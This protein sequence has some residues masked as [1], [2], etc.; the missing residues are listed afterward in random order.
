MFLVWGEDLSATLTD[1]TLR[2]D[3]RATGAVRL[4]VNLDDEHVAPALR[5]GTGDPIGA[6]VS[7]WGPDPEAAARVLAARATTAGW[8]FEERRRV[9]PAERK[10]AV[11]SP[12]ATLAPRRW[13]RGVNRR[14]WRRPRGLR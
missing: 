2:E 5:F 1:P 13:K 3:L 4:Q 14:S 9:D 10:N 6:V 7:V 8:L 12:P 11:R